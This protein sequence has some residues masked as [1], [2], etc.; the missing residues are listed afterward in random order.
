M[1]ARKKYADLDA[2][3]LAQAASG[4]PP[5]SSAPSAATPSASNPVSSIKPKVVAE[6]PVEQISL[7]LRKSV[8]KQLKRLADEADVT[9]QVFILRALQKAG[10]VLT[11]DD[12]RDRRKE[13]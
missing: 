2:V 4:L 11:E 6:E 1:S 5:T 3:A 10:I 9:Q 13:R 8:K 12:L 7:R